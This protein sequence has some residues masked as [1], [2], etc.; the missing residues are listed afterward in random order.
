VSG[1]LTHPGIINPNNSYTIAC[2]TR[3]PGGAHSPLRRWHHHDYFFL[4]SYGE[5][6]VESEADDHRCK[7]LQVIYLRLLYWPWFLID[8]TEGAEVVSVRCPQRDALHKTATRIRQQLT[9]LRV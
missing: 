1:S 9:D 5:Q 2:D 6:P 3:C 4:P 7:I 8:H